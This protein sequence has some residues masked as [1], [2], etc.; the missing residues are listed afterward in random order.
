M[1]NIS[2]DFWNMDLIVCMWQGRILAGKMAKIL[3]RSFELSGE[4][5]EQISRTFVAIF[6]YDKK[7]LTFVAFSYQSYAILQNFLPRIEILCR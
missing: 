6:I 5:F 2:L 4:L 1:L 3:P 7:S